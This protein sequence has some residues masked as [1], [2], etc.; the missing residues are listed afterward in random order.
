MHRAYRRSWGFPRPEA[1]AFYVGG[2]GPSDE[3]FGEGRTFT[4]EFGE[5]GE[6]GGA[7]FGIFGV[8]R[9]L[10]FLAHKLGLD[11]EQIKRLAP[12]LDDLKTERA[13]AAVD[14]RRTL[15]SFADAVAGESFD[16]AKGAA[17]GSLRVE[18]AERLKTAVLDALRRI[19]GL[20]RPDQRDQLA[21]LIR[22]GRLTL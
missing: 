20:L 18:G 19:H 11:E 21:Y 6:L 4:I 9:P 2:C 22:T 13:Q 1:R 7:S 17:G 12:I 14:S 15:A 3:S 16:E 10:R 5:E 8:R